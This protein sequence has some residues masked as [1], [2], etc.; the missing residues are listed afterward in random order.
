M[1]KLPLVSVLDAP[2]ISDAL[3]VSAE[4]TDGTVRWWLRGRDPTLHETAA[5][6]GL[7]EVRRLHQMRV[8]LPLEE[9]SDLPVRA[10]RP[11]IDD[12]AW[13]AT[14]NR[15]FVWH[16][17]QSNW[18][19]ED[20]QRRMAEPWFEAEG[21]LLLDGPD[22]SVAGFCWTKLHNKHTP[23]MGEIYVIGVDPDQQGRG[24]GRQLAIAGLG[25]QWDHHQPQVGMLY[26]EHDNAA[27]IHLYEELGFTIHHDDVAYELVDSVRS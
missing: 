18:T 19:V 4:T 8:P 17:D 23:V 20:L 10:F 9:Q 1:P 16:P 3:G 15:A 5:R 25:W 27:A 6:L 12:E 22:G 11:G 24:L 13:L 14:N 2:G 7:A 21:F 26:V